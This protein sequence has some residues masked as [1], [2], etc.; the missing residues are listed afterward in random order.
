[1]K[2]I[3]QY[4]AFS[5]CFILVLSI[6]LQNNA[7]YGSDGSEGSVSVNKSIK[8]LDVNEGLAEI[9]VNV[10]ASDQD[11][12]TTNTETTDIVLVLDVSNSMKGDKLKNAKIAAS[13]FATTMLD[14]DP[15]GKLR[16]AVVEY[17]DEATT[18]AT[19][20]NSKTTVLNAINSVSTPSNYNDGG[21]NIQAGLKTARTLLEDSKA[22][23]K[24]LILLSDGEPTYSYEI[25]DAEFT[26]SQNDN[27]KGIEDKLKHAVK[28][29]AVSSY[30]VKAVDYKSVKGS[31]QYFTLFNP[32]SKLITLECSHGDI[33]GDYQAVLP[34][35]HG[36]ATIYEASLCKDTS[37]Y[38]I[39]FGI[40]TGSNAE[41]VLKD[42]A[43]EGQYFLSD[44]SE[45]EINKVFSDIQSSVTSKIAAGEDATVTSPKKEVYVGE[46][47]DK[48]LAD[49]TVVDGSITTDTGTAELKDGQVS[50]DIGTLPNG[51]ATLKYRIKIDMSKISSGN[52]ITI[53]P[54]KL[55]YK[56]YNGDQLATINS[57][58]DSNSVDLEFFRVVFK[59]ADENNT[60]LKTQFVGKNG[61]ATAP[62]DPTIADTVQYKYT[63][64]G[65]DGNY[66]NVSKDEVV[67]AKY[68][69]VLQT[70]TVTFKLDGEVV[71]TET[72]EYGKDATA[73]EVTKEESRNYSD[74]VGNYTNVMKDEEVNMT[75]S[76]KAFTVTFYV[77]G[78]VVK[79]EIVEYG[80]DAT[81]PE[82][83]KEE[84]RNYSDW[85]G[86][87]TNVTKDEEVNMTSSI[88]TFT[89]TFYVD[90]EFV[91][92]EIVEY[93]KDATTPE[94]TKEESRNY[95]D[96]V[97]NYTNVTKDEEVNMT[98]S[99]KTFT[100]TFYVDGEFVKEEI[101]EYG[102]DATAPTVEKDETKDYSDWIGNYA[103]VVK[104]EVVFMT[105]SIKTFTVTFY[106]DGEILKTETVEYGKDAT[107]PEV[108]KEE[109]RNYSDWVGNY[110]NVTKDEEVNMTSSIKMFTV[111]FKLDGE[112][113]KEET[114]EYGKDATAPEVTKE[115]SRNYSD[116]V[117]N[118]TNV[119]KDEEVN[120]TSSVKTFTVTFY[121]DG[122]VVKEETV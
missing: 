34:N 30:T 63:F 26:V 100:V 72:V 120:M 97:G 32:Y 106:V 118:Y 70:Y 28:D 82:V 8:W 42:I 52:E 64:A 29:V 25:T 107:A 40:E 14:G 23:N 1:M 101:V 10:T 96:W 87:Y 98:S 50:W 39:G 37:I 99:I 78:E 59:N 4:I 46:M 113:V 83:T 2:K 111:A 108:T 56:P 75:S 79:E 76:V 68:D 5:L 41:H 102:K 11:I 71:K 103:N 117:G 85:V 114:V 51:M 116:W 55:T 66:E 48:V 105:S 61:N 31:G 33:V 110:T 92:E 60:I 89:V 38:S 65:W 84:S 7:V 122:E 35:N 36:V 74:W 93:G 47:V 58:V 3:E 43:D 88:K 13:K 21:T 19:F 16:I 53:A 12:T 44:I 69:T 77:D 112:V 57:T 91:K 49:Y 104:D 90:G 109:S 81:A 54:S 45:A 24:F 119:T 20:S 67:I 80:K 27:C 18:V 22:N 6:V 86:N 17:Y 121:V 73:P 15:T 62:E 94:V 115:E 9:T 95:S